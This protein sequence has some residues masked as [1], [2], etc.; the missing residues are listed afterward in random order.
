MSFLISGIFEIIKL[1]KKQV[2]V[3][4]SETKIS[5]TKINTLSGTILVNTEITTKCITYTPNE[6]FDRCDIKLVNF[7]GLVF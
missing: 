2:T 6:S 1:T 3:V 5:F 4:A 7:E